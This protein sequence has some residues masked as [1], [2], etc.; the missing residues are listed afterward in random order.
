MNRLLS[1]GSKLAL[2][3][4]LTTAAVSCN[5]NQ[6]ASTTNK[7]ADATSASNVSNAEKIVYVN[8]DTLSE[9]YEYFKDIRTKMESKVKK[10]QQNLQ[11]KGQAFQRE[12]ADY[13]QKA[14]TMSASDR[15]A[16]EEKLARKQQELGQLD[17]NASAAI[18]QEEAKEFNAVYT[19][20]TDYLKKHAEEKGYSLVLTYSKSNPTVLYADSKMEITNEVVAGLNKEYST[21]KSSEKK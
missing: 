9:K 19:A 20:V 15:Q 11:A 5:Q 1:T 7:P 18:Q 2:G 8:S 16:T 17:Q 10:E 13:Q 6:P 3:L 12:V 14:Q 4:I 21:K